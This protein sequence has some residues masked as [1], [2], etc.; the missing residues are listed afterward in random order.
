MSTPIGLPGRGRT[1]KK[2]EWIVADR[3]GAD[4]RLVDV[5]RVTGH[6]RQRVVDEDEHFVDVDA[7]RELQLDLGARLS[8]R[9]R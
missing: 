5:L 1:A 6:L 2:H 4:A 9:V 3:A 8:T 7:E